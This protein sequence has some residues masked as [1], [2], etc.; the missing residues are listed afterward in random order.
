MKVVELRKCIKTTEIMVQLRSIKQH[1]GFILI[2]NISGRLD[3]FKFTG[4]PT[5]R[6]DT[7]SAYLGQLFI[8]LSILGCQ[9]NLVQRYLSMKSEKE[10]KRLVCQRK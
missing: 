5:T 6:V 3:L 9:Q 1:N 4:D 7:G 8:S 2:P 10:V